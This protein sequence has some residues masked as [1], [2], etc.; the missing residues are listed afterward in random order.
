MSDQRASGLE[1]L[2]RRE[3]LER[4]PRLGLSLERTVQSAIEVADE[5]GLAAVSMKRVAERLGFTT[6]AVYRYVASK[7]ELLLLMQDTVA[8]PPAGLDVL[9][10]TAGWRSG[11]VQWTRAQYEIVEAHPWLEEI[12]PF[13]RTGTPSQLSWMDL[14]LRVLG[15][16]PLT[17]YQKLAVLLLLG[18]YVSTQAR[19]ALTAVEGVRRGA[20]ATT[21]E[22]TEAFGRLLSQVVTPDRFPALV[23]AVRGGAFAPR[24]G[25][26]YATFDFGLDLM[27]DGVDELIRR[28]APSGS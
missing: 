7:D 5:E 12:R 27:L 9:L 1:R 25:P 22:A 16:T 18:G 15:A 21:D 3:E 28:G 24:E 13:E 19:L 17:E 6:M 14:G 11:L 26:T 23:R 2:W 8:T 10:E 4:P 20:F